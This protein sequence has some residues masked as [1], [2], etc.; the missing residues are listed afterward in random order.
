MTHASHRVEHGARLV[1]VLRLRRRVCED[2]RV[3]QRVQVHGVVV[4]PVDGLLEEGQRA[5]V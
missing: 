4:L 3:G 5:Q 2:H 1:L